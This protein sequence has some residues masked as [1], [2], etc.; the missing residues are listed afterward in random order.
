MTTWFVTGAGRGL[1]HAIARHALEAGDSVV[2]TT[3]NAA[4]LESVFA[5]AGDQFL[6]VQLE[7]TDPTDAA[8]A[9]DAAMDRFGQIDVLVNNAGRGLLG[10]VEEASPEE[11][12]DVFATNVFGLLTVTRAIL[13]HMR[14]ARSGR[15][16]NIGSMGGFAQVAGWGVY[17][18][19]KFAVEGLTEAMQAELAPLGIS[20]TVVEPGSFRTDFLDSGSLETTA[21]QIDDYAE[22]AGRVR[23]AV[24]A[25]GGR[26]PNDPVRGAAALYAA[27]MSESPPLRLQLGAD[28]VAMVE[29]KLSR[30][31]DELDSWRQVSLSTAFTEQ[32]PTA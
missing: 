11:T 3:R 25:S 26:Q 2:G 20:V 29:G 17:G 19:T 13:P 4:Q 9:V 32:E 5:G 16:V 6:P 27:V 30:V 14:E 31:R 1:G 24:A 7:I 28:A 23:R 22:T 8:R 18:A 21:R 12:Q 15:I 10:A